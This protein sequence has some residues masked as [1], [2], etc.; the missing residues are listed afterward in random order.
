[1]T[2]VEILVEEHALIRQGLDNLSLA[3]EKLEEGEK[4]PAEFFEAAIRF[5]R[6]FSD[7]FHHFKEEYLMFTRL[8]ERNNGAIDAQID[9]LRV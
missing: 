8:A 3:I 7:K 5:A 1:M 6:T 9:A 2:P 4:P